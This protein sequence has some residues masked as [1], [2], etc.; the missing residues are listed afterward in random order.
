MAVA[1]AAAAQ[2]MMMMMSDAH[3][4]VVEEADGAPTLA[5]GGGWNEARGEEAAVR[6]WAQTSPWAAVAAAREGCICR[7]AQARW[8]MEGMTG[9]ADLVPNVWTRNMDT[10]RVI[11]MHR[12]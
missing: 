3:R 6:R 9:G 12:P 11:H 4:R 1:A 2:E 7:L 8:H 5:P 10:D